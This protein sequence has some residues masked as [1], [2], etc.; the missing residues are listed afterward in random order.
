MLEAKGEQAGNRRRT[1]AQRADKQGY[2]GLFFSRN[3][4]SPHCTAVSS[5]QVSQFWDN[6]PGARTFLESHFFEHTLDMSENL[7]KLSAKSS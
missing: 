2:L 1:G 7:S 3:A 6:Q 4:I 5:T